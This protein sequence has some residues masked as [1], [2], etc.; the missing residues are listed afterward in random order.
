MNCVW[1]GGVTAC[2]EYVEAVDQELLPAR[3]LNGA[4][5]DRRYL[6]PAP[7]NA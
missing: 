4:T 1:R 7:E 6:A 5:E 3:V 2:F